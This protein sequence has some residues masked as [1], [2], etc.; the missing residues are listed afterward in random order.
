MGMAIRTPKFGG[1]YSRNK[2]LEESGR[3][4]ESLTHVSA[5]L[6]APAYMCGLETTA[7]TEVQVCK[8]NWIR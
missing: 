6:L 5:Q 7:L 2:R 3:G 1:G 8:H 4:N